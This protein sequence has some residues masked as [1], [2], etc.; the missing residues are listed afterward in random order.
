MLVKEEGDTDDGV[1]AM[2]KNNTSN[3]KN[4][5]IIPTQVLKSWPTD[6]Q[7]SFFPS[8]CTLLSI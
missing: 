5:T 6:K 7:A 3:H 1:F 2:R 8:S 4:A